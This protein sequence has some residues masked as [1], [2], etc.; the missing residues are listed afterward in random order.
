[1]ATKL[2]SSP[3]EV[4]LDFSDILAQPGVVME[5]RDDVLRDLMSSSAPLERPPVNDIHSDR[6]PIRTCV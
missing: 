1:M 5:V 3:G 6:L 4:G 2:I